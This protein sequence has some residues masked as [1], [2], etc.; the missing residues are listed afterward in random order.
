MGCRRCLLRASC[1]LGVI[2]NCSAYIQSPAMPRQAI[3]AV[4][5][6]AAKAGFYEVRRDTS[7]RCAMGT[8]VLRKLL[9]AV[10]A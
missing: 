3:I 10:R 5:C 4:D 8:R 7:K 6:A 9:K 1:A 2:V